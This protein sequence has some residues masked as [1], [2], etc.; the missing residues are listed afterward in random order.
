MPRAGSPF[1]PGVLP[2]TLPPPA[3]TAAPATMRSEGGE[4]SC[5]VLT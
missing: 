4:A 5:A 1:Q 2:N 3:A